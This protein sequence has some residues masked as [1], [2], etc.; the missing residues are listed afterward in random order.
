MSEKFEEWFE[1]LEENSLP[2][3]KET[4]NGKTVTYKIEFMES[5]RFMWNLL[6]SLVNSLTKWI[7]KDW[8]WIQNTLSGSKRKHAQIQM[9]SLQ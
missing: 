2:I 5:V 3:K 1:C 4:E 9:Y 7:H 8:S 6:W